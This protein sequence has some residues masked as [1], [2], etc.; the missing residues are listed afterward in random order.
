M[1]LASALLF[2]A[3]MH[4]AAPC[5]ATVHELRVRVPAGHVI[6]ARL[7][8]P[9]G[10]RRAPVI[11]TISG[12]G[13]HGRDYST[14]ASTQFANHFFRELEDRLGCIGIGTVRFDEVGTGHSTGAYAAYA[15]TRS[16]AD[17]VLALVDAL[18]QRPDVDPA[19]VAL[20]GHSEGGAIAAIAAAERPSIAAVVLLGAPVQQGHDIMRFQI[21]EEERRSA[22]AGDTARREHARR[23]AGDA[24]YQFF[25]DFS[26]A[27]FYRRLSQPVLILH[28]EYDDSVTPDQADAILELARSGGVRFGYCRRYPDHGHAF[29]GNVPRIAAAAPEVLDDIVRFAH[30]AM[31]ARK[32]PALPA[33]ACRREGSGPFRPAGA[34]AGEPAPR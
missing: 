31:V 26:P 11:I 33:G 28:G 24:W 10:A 17:D 23:T 30:K 2:S 19:R 5:P 12:A 6:A 1:S 21:A 7:A 15:T 20:L 4:A 29:I 8:L 34:P 16:L 25:L 27:P 9:A 13:P 22:A 32:P 18:Q 3:L 14:V